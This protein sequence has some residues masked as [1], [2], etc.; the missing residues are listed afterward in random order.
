MPRGEKQKSAG[1]SS[2]A[3]SSCW[4]WKSNRD[5]VDDVDDRD[6]KVAE[7]ARQ[8]VVDQAEKANENRRAQERQRFFQNRVKI[9]DSEK[10]RE[11][12]RQGRKLK[13]EGRQREDRQAT[14]NCFREEGQ[15]VNELKRGDDS[16]N[17]VGGALSGA[18]EK[19]SLSESA[20]GKDRGNS[21]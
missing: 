9:K 20:S 5:D 17:K 21:V 2:S 6:A 13:T 18:L 1:S 12:T 8:K 11:E 16:H 10:E 14:V 4:P 19:L 7:E 3:G 15:I